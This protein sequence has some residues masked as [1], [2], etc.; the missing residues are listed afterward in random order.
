MSETKKPQRSRGKA[1]RKSGRAGKRPTGQAGA[2][3]KRSGN[4]PRRPASGFKAKRR[5]SRPDKAGSARKAPLPKPQERLKHQGK[6]QDEIMRHK[7]EEL[8]GRQQRMPPTDLRA[9][10]VTAPD[11]LDF[12]AALRGPGVSLIAEV[13]RASPSRGLLCPDFDPAMLARTYLAGGAAAISVLTDSRFFQGQL[14]YLTTVA[15]VCKPANRGIPVL[16]KDFI[17]DP[18]Q[19]VEARVAGADALLL[20]VAVLGDNDLRSLLAETRRLGM[21]ALVE[22]HDEAEVERALAAGAQV[23]GVNNRDLQTFSTSLDTTARL[24]PLIP[25][26]KVVVSESGI[27]TSADVRRLAGLG[28]HAILVGESLVA[29]HPRDRLKQV[30]KLVRAGG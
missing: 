26:D 10:A 22:V 11:P 14:E 23:I 30:K 29:A 25:D 12:V 28:V 16:R 24:R 18:Y 21:E 9:L 1:S 17:F 20:I 27:H 4:A 15:G 8:P 5:G 2:K 19:V 6:M 13:K 7:R 3:R